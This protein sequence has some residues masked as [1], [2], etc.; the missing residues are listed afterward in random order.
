MRWWVAVFVVSVSATGLAEAA[1]P[2]RAACKAT[3]VTCLADVKEAFKT[4]KLACDTDADRVAC[5]AAAKQ[6]ARPTARAAR[7]RSNPAGKAA[8]VL[9][10]A[11][12]TAARRGI[13]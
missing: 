3:K 8:V 13:G 11:A 5:I 7:R 2:C 1:D 4:A 10:V 12:P 6:P 9:A